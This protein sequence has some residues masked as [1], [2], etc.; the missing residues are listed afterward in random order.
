M[1]N[2]TILTTFLLL[3]GVAHATIYTVDNNLNSGA[4]F[5]DLQA[6]VDSADNGDT[7]LVSG[8]GTHYGDITINKKLILIGAGYN[9]NNQTGLWS[10]MT[11]LRLD[12]L[13]GVFAGSFIT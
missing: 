8:S 2:L 13:N 7:I 1:K 11:V 6:A 9:P 10:R 5:T 12:S 4:M 3:F